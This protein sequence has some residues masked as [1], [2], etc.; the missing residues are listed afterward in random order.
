MFVK[1]TR[2]E[3]EAMTLDEVKAYNKELR[4]YE[5]KQKL[6]KASTIEDANS[7]QQDL[8]AIVDQQKKK[9]VEDKDLEQEFYGVVAR[10]EQVEKKSSPTF[11]SFKLDKDLA[12]KHG[13][14]ASDVASVAKDLA[15]ALP[16]LDFL[17]QA[18]GRPVTELKTFKKFFGETGAK[19]FKD[20]FDAI[21][22][23][24]NK[25]ALS[26]K[27]MYST[28]SGVGDEWVPTDFE[29][30][31]L[32][33]IQ[34]AKAI[35]SNIRSFDM[36]S[37]IFEWPVSNSAN[38]TYSGAE[39]GGSDVT[40]AASNSS[41]GKI[42]WSAGKL[43]N[44]LDFSE[45]LNED[46]AFAL[47][48]ALTAITGDSLGDAYERCILFGDE[49]TGGSSNINLIDG[50]P[51]TTAGSASNYLACDGLIHKALVDSNGTA[52]D[53]NAYSSVSRGM[54]KVLS[55]MGEGAQNVSSLRAIFNPSLLWLA[56][57][58]SQVQTVDKIGN[59]ASILTGMVGRIN[60]IPVFMSG[61]IPKTNAAGK[62]PAAGGTLGSFVIYDMNYVLVG[63][64][65]R[66]RQAMDYVVE[67]DKHKLV[68]SM[69]FDVQQLVAN[70][71][72]KNPIGYGYNYPL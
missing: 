72:G 51:T 26:K 30:S 68:T 50:T 39:S 46:S 71:A 14:N 32:M 66:M 48:P 20:S 38:T 35:P 23:H 41:S 69:R 6:I 63:F 17:K 11:G 62:I 58:D 60:G 55:E 4:E 42:T 64:R 2:E 12:K 27:T 24:N 36:T 1:K 3:L 43:F 8:G 5:E 16:A 65:R 59:A 10:L 56:M 44:R 70:S 47:M 45:E 54:N 15:S 22:D 37:G 28:G 33:H 57:N 67:T 13:A 21:T 31:L 49:T 18:T 19:H 52:E 25:A 9:G 61:G 40:V 29:S 53:I 7:P 34:S